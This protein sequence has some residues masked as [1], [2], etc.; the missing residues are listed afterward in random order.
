MQD[1]ADMIRTWQPKQQHLW[2]IIIPGVPGLTGHVDTLQLSLRS[3]A[4]PSES[5][6]VITVPMDSTEAKFAGK[7]TFADIELVFSDWIDR[8]TALLIRNWRSKVFNPLNG[9]AGLVAQYKLDGFAKV[10]SDQTEEFIAEYILKGCWPKDGNWGSLD[11]NS[12][13]LVQIR[14]PL[15]IDRGYLKS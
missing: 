3:A 13:D 14:V 5:T 15:V 7:T 12:A 6:G 4:L 2:D 1:R 8:D 9:G 10:Y 11:R